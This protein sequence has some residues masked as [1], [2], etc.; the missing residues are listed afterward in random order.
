MTSNPED[1]NTDAV[2]KLDKTL[3]SHGSLLHVTPSFFE[4]QADGVSLSLCTSVIPAATEL[5]IP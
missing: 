3:E 4:F 1:G 2:R 5:L